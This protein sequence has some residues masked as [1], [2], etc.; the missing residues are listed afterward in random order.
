MFRLG[1]DYGT[2]STAAVLAWPDGRRRPL[3]FDGSPL[4]PSAVYAE[5]E[6][7][8][9]TGRDAIRAARIDPAGL[10]PNPKRRI[11]DGEV[12]L[13]S[14]VFAVSD[15][16]AAT[17]ARVWREA[18]RTAG[19]PPASV[20]LT[21]PAAWG[22]RRREVVAMA[23]AA[24]G[25]PRP[26]LVAEPVAAACYFAEVRRQEVPS[27][28]C[29]IV[30][31]LGA[32]TFDVSVVRRNGPGFETLACD[33]I[34]SFGGIDLDEL[35]V[36]LVGGGLPQQVDRRQWDAL[37]RPQRRDDNRLALELR[38]SARE[39]KES[40]SRQPSAMVRI[41]LLELAVPVTREQ[42]DAAAAPLLRQSVDLTLAAAREA[43]VGVT[44]LAGV[45][46]VGGA[47]RMPL[48]A[49]LLHRATTVAP[50][51]LEQ[52]ELVVAEGALLAAEGSTPMVA[53]TSGPPA[54]GARSV[55][56]APSAPLRSRPVGPDETHAGNG[57]S[58]QAQSGDPGVA[59]AGMEI[60]PVRPPRPSAADR[61]P[62]ALFSAVLMVLVAWLAVVVYQVGTE[63]A[64]TPTAAGKGPA[65]PSAS[66]TP[67]VD[68]SSSP[69]DP[70]AGAG[71]G[72]TVPGS[73]APKVGRPGAT[74]PTIGLSPNSGKVNAKFTVTGQGF[75]PNAKI[76]IRFHTDQVATAT[77][78]A[79]GSFT[80]TATVPASFAHFAGS[81]SVVAEQSSP[82]ADAREQFTVT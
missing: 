9:L 77:A 79:N 16:I 43:K 2:S 81:W 26:V 36:S 80:V 41:P 40:L 6:A 33:G 21:V 22:G 7:A 31:D 45:F 78:D 15:L 17:L 4:L 30:Y 70:G 11:D 5:R 64:A 19:Q 66:S 42:L 47:T 13:G 27:G 48:V 23:A 75:A 44:Q 20:V 1:I 24:A 82:L 63:T 28:Q 3:L 14:A 50:L 60:I 69:S 73:P 74:E 76:K 12:L 10:D 62:A 55:S 38:D 25:M 39:A 37:V 34:D 54:M 53:A 18:L 71:P 68:A 65:S 58:G 57:Q 32:G 51:A 59:R 67:A 35:V 61:V 56:V 49:T 8:L 52:P 72:A 29:V 46:L